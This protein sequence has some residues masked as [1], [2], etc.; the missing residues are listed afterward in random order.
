MGY[1][2]EESIGERDG[3]Q[4]GVCQHDRV[5]QWNFPSVRSQLESIGVSC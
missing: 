4:E 1:P 5:E 3:G 2:G